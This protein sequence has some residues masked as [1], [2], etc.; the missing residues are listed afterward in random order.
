MSDYP[1]TGDATDGGSDQEVLKK[2]ESG[3]AKGRD[4]PETHTDV[5]SNHTDALNVGPFSIDIVPISV[6]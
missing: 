6:I 5:T 1:T 3:R 2:E 4:A